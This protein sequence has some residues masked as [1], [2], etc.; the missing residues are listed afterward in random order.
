MNDYMKR[1]EILSRY[2]MNEG[3]REKKTKE[4][5]KKGVQKRQLWQYD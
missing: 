5:A 1:K 4:A 2:R 3:E